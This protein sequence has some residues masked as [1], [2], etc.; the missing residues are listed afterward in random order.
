M[1][2]NLAKIKTVDEMLSSKSSIGEELS[3]KEIKSMNSTFNEMI[4]LKKGIAASHN[5]SATTAKNLGRGKGKF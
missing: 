4:E 5:I 2:N 1:K 3:S